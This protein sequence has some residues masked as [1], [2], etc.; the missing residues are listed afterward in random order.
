MALIFPNQ[1]L[2]NS[3]FAVLTLIYL[4][5]SGDLNIFIVAHNLQ[6]ETNKW[7]Y[8][9]EVASTTAHYTDYIITIV[10]H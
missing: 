4:P 1:K 3:I 8:C 6:G 9:N 7:I 5:Q 2:A 10:Q